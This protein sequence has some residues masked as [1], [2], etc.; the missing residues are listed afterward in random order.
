V[1]YQLAQK[2]HACTEVFDEGPDNPRFRDLIDILLLRSLIEGEA[3]AEVRVACVDVFSVRDKHS[4]P[5]SLSVPPSWRDPYTHLADETGFGITEVE[6]AA[7]AVRA[8]IAEIDASTGT[9]TLR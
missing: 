8:V 5:P 2:L 1:P 4:W 7:A 9:D 3:L 6:D